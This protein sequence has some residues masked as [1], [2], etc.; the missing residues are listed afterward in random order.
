M[1]GALMQVARF[2]TNRL[3]LNVKPLA[4]SRHQ[5]GAGC[6]T[7]L[8]TL[9]FEDATAPFTGFLDCVILVSANAVHEEPVIEDGKIVIGR[10]MRCNFV[11]DHRFV[12]GGKAK[13]LVKTFKEIF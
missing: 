11:V 1:V 4:L 9:G 5:F 7:S 10:V 2:F 8:G 6:V 3:G 12:D 13:S